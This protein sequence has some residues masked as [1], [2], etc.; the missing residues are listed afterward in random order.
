VAK[1]N[2]H[3][4]REALETYNRD[5]F[6]A[7]IPFTSPAIEVHA[8]PGLLNSGEFKGIDAATQFNADWEE[9]WGDVRYEPV[10]LVELDD[11][12]VL[13]VVAGTM[14]GERSGVQINSQQYWL[15]AI[16]DGRFARWHLCLDRESAIAAAGG[17]DD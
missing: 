14:R 11:R 6:G 15:F 13:A 9:A 12:H 4:V 16:E 17:R 8:A 2:T 7:L 10:E 3:L 1:S 5:G